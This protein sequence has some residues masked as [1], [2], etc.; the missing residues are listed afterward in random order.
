MVKT[1]ELSPQDEAEM[2][3]IMEGEIEQLDRLISDVVAITVAE[4]E[5]FSVQQHP[6]S[7]RVLLENAAALARTSL[8]DHPFAMS[9]VPEVRVDCDPERISQV[10][11]NLLDN[12]AKHTPPGTPIELRAHHA[13][14]QVRI[15]VADQGS[16][17]SEEDVDVAFEKFGRGH[18]S[19]AQQTPGAGLGL[20]LSRQIIQAHGSELRVASVPGSET[21]FA[22]D[23]Q[24]SP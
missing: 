23:L 1:G 24:V 21:I 22:F 5:D 12:A 9:D 18:R 20:Y 6:I 3:T 17:L 10:L 13:G 16:G 8:G 15:E 19:A 14:M 11:R 4:R 7:L 2:L